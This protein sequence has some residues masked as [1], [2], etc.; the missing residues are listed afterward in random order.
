MKK[1]K[2]KIFIVDDE[3]IIVSDLKCLLESLKY[4]VVGTAL[5]SDEALYKVREA[6]PDVVL[7]DIVLIGSEMDGIEVS[8]VIKKELDISIIFL[9]GY[10]D[11]EFLNR[12]QEVNPFGYILKP[13]QELEVKAAIEIAFTKKKAERKL[14]ESGRRYRLLFENAPTINIIIGNNLEFQ[15]VN[16]TFIETFGYSR[17]EIVGKPILDFVVAKQKQ[18]LTDQLNIAQMGQFTPEIDIDFI[19]KNGMIHT[20]LLAAGEKLLYKGGEPESVIL[21]GMDFT[22][23]KKSEEDLQHSEARLYNIIQKNAD[24]ILIIDKKGEICFVNPAAERLFG[25]CATDLI[26]DVFGYPAVNGDQTEIEIVRNENEKI[27]VELQVVE[28]EW[29]GEKHFLASLRDTTARKAAEKKLITAYREL[30]ITQEQLIQSEK[31]AAL[32]RFA[33]GVSHELKNPLGIILG[34]L[35]YLERKITPDDNDISIT[36]EKMKKTIFRADKII[37]DILKYSKPAELRKKK[38]NPEEIIEE[39]LELFKQKISLNNIVLEKKY[40]EQDF[41]IEVDRNQMLQVL[42]NI[43]DNAIQ[44]MPEGG[45]IKINISK[46]NDMISRLIGGG[47]NCVI[48]ISDSGK[49]I[50]SKQLDQV[51]EPFFSTKKKGA[52][53]GL[54]LAVVKTIIN[55]HKG[56]ISISSK[57]GKGTKITITLPINQR[58]KNEKKDF[59]NR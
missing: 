33:S 39:A 57:K 26:G 50:P 46:E 34:G 12:A 35:E 21:I 54:G 41:T 4:N 27:F 22:E 3:A 32:G 43:L 58:G 40:D 29:D 55:N 25:L 2:P 28:T 38:I 8:E 51:F 18:L 15:E 7:M 19:A 45:S 56:E 48:E 5:S 13:F 17:T 42:F 52:G 1:S 36:L 9:T 53:T 23:R 20:V 10:A 16:S 44:A 6:A 59:G 11:D 24:G 30:K 31:L 47:E 37:K 14:V 49:G